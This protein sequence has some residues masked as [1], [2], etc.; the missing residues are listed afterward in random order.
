MNE[1]EVQKA[2]EY[3]EMQE[4]LSPYSVNVLSGNLAIA[5]QSMKKQLPLQVIREPAVWPDG[6]ERMKLFC[7]ACHGELSTD[8]KHCPHS[9]QKLEWGYY[10]KINRA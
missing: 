8:E 10:E 1:S 3:W 2:I 4:Q 9:E 5:I 7:P 6:Q